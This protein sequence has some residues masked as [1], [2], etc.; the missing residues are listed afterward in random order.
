VHAL[1]PSIPRVQCHTRNTLSALQIRIA[2]QAVAEA[3]TVHEA[4]IPLRLR[5]LDISVDDFQ[6]FPGLLVR[7]LN[8][9]PPGNFSVKP[10]MGILLLSIG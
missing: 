6:A 8:P 4:E 1:C 2:K 9:R 5:Q 10:S 7:F 3:G